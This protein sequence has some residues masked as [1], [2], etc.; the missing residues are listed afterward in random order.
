MGFWDVAAGPIAIGAGSLIDAIGGERANRAAKAAA[1]EQMGFQERMS[2]SAHQREVADLRAAGLN[3]IL[4]AGGNGASSPSGAS[5]SPENVFEGASNTA[6][7]AVRLKE[8]IKAIRAGV[9]KT[10]ADASISEATLPSV[11]LDANEAESM[12]KHLY[13]LF[14]SLLRKLG[15]W[16]KR[17]MSDVDRIGEFNLD[18]LRNSAKSRPD[19]KPVRR[20]PQVNRPGMD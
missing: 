9:R 6:L 10:N 11:R 15:L 16:G 3:P 2:S 20:V 5:Y 12:N 17:T 19:L 1:A 18:D 8:E 13:P 14:D 7:A 4:S